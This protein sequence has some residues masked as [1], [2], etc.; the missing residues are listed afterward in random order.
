MSQQQLPTPSQPT[1]VWRYLGKQL[2]TLITIIGMI[3]M[4]ALLLG[5]IAAALLAGHNEQRTTDL[6]I[7]A[8][9]RMLAPALVDQIV[10]LHDQ[11]LVREIILVGEGGGELQA[12]L[13]ARGVADSVLITGPDS[14]DLHS[15]SGMAILKRTQSVTVIT[16]PPLQ[17]STVK[18]M[19]DQGLRAYH[20]PMQGS[21]F[22]IR[23]LL[24]ASLIYWRYVLGQGA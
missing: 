14:L 19:R 7:V 22:N 23:D 16:T 12:A 10:N 1:L 18:F 8:T 5:V 3:G 15:L 21:T 2:L 17:L 4:T 6:A 20:V 13:I 24:E 11:Q 9:P